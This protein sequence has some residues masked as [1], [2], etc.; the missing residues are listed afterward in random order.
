MLFPPTH[1]LY[2]GLELLHSC[3]QL[4][5]LTVTIQLILWSYNE[6]LLHQSAFGFEPL[7]LMYRRFHLLFQYLESKLPVC[8][9]FFLNIHLLGHVT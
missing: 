2:K 1:Q 4:Y 7:Q 5:L 9:Y 3:L 6:L 8:D